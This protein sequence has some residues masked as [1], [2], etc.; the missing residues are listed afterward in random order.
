[1]S[2][3]ETILRAL[4]DCLGPGECPAP[5]AG[6]AP[7]YGAD[8]WAL[9]RE[10][11]ETRGARYIGVRDMKEAAEALRGLLN[12][13]GVESALA[14]DHP[15]LEALGL[16]GIL[17]DAG[18]ERISCDDTLSRR[19]A[20]DIG[21]TSAVAVMPEAGSVVVVAGDGTA[22]QTSL[23][24]PVHVAMAPAGRSV[25]TIE[26]LPAFVRS[27]KLADG[28]LPSALHI[29]TGPSSTADIEKTVVKGVH[30]PTACVII[31]VEG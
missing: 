22:R 6:D 20:T 29:I 23:L 13:F 1:M 19:E 16:E 18:V 7:A 15:D 28:L 8:D 26:D 12:E 3:R 9:L 5:A 27:L 11:A 4:H 17:A 31:A 2:A 21:I 30:G 14:W 25:P 24:P 10:R